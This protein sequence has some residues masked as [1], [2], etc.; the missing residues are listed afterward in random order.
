MTPHIVRGHWIHESYGQGRK[1]RRLQWIELFIRGPESAPFDSDFPVRRSSPIG[2]KK[3][4]KP[5]NC[6]HCGYHVSVIGVSKQPRAEDRTMTRRIE[7]GKDMPACRAAMAA[8]VEALD[9][10][11]TRRG[12]P[13]PP[14][15]PQWSTRVRQA[16]LYWVSR[17]MTAL[18]LDA[19]TDMPAWTVAAAL[20]CPTGLLMWAGPLPPVTCLTAYQASAAAPLTV[21][22]PLRGVLWGVIGAQLQVILVLDDQATSVRVGNVVSV[23]LDGDGTSGAYAPACPEVG[24]VMALVGATWTLMAQPQVAERR[25]R[26]QS[27]RDVQRATR[28]GESTSPVTIVDLRPLRT[29]PATDRD[30]TGRRLHT[31]F[32]VRG[33]WRQ[34]YHPSDHSH[35]P[36]WIN[37]YLKGPEGAPLKTTDTV[38]V[39][40]R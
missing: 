6:W 19:S 37:S 25:R 15:T 11:M 34:Q 14:G 30:G 12:H 4:K 33:H 31:R 29:Q 38:R 23:P 9:A 13:A 32:L 27:R 7:Q 1:L 2:C 3:V 17:D 21:R 10:D 28:T 35:R 39:W 22:Q 24:A 40:R 36:R 20:P 5:R 16:D 26:D 8:E 18:A